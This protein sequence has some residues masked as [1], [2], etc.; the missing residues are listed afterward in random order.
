M[1]TT[2]NSFLE[3]TKL[4]RKFQERFAYRTS[5]KSDTY[6]LLKVG[7]TREEHDKL[8]NKELKE[9]PWKYTVRQVSTMELLIISAMVL[10]PSLVYGVIIMS[11]PNSKYQLAS[12]RN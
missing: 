8:L 2:L 11:L 1:K 7:L 9:N 10:L 6:L 4:W 5:H 3:D 12:F